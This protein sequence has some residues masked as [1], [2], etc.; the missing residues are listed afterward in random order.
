M[1][2]FSIKGSSS[3]VATFAIT[4][5][6]S[7]TA[8]AQ[9]SALPPARTYH[10][11]Q[12]GQP[13]RV[14]K[15]RWQDNTNGEKQGV[16]LLY[17][18]KG[19]PITKF[20]YV[21]G[22]KSGPAFIVG[23]DYFYSI[24]FRLTVKFIGTFLNGKEEGWWEVFDVGL[25]GETGS[26]DRRMKYVAGNLEYVNTFR[27]GRMTASYKYE[28]GKKNG[29]AKIYGPTSE[30]Y[31]TGRYSNNILVGS[32]TNAGLEANKIIY[33][34]NGRLVFENGEL[35]SIINPD[36]SIRSI[37]AEKAQKEAELQRLDASQKATAQASALDTRLNSLDPVQF[38]F[39]TDSYVL[40]GLG[41]TK[42]DT[43][44]KQ[45][46]MRQRLTQYQVKDLYMPVY[47]NPMA[48][49]A[50][51]AN[52]KML[53]ILSINRA[54]VIKQYL[55]TKL[56]DKSLSLAVFPCGGSIKDMNSMVK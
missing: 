41:K 10:V 56:E 23:E 31:A 45:L 32:W 27:N 48:W 55:F 7:V 1:N 18:S 4:S 12:Y 44:A 14:V 6:A 54:C 9:S 25:N 30:E 19:L 26:L 42:L 35:T 28:S 38:G 47:T 16:Y 17:N 50:N 49:N 3:I 36:G 46:N 13:T 34:R 33:R 2:L 39:Y 53:Y 22:V 15:E 8:L 29:L 11:D 37:T 43:L 40:T 51:E 20:T 21:N 52:E 5:L 24:S